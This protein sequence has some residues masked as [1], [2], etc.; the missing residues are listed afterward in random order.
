[1]AA[2]YTI[3]T[4]FEAVQY[5]GA[6]SSKIADFADAALSLTI[7]NYPHGVGSWIIKTSSL[8]FII[9]SDQAFKALFTR[10]KLIDN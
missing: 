6:N 10:L 2:I 9:I 7:S 3:K 5:T 4:P 1:M 8:Q